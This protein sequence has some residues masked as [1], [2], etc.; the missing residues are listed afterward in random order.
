MTWAWPRPTHNTSARAAAPKSRFMTQ[1]YDTGAARLEKKST[2]PHDRGSDRQAKPP[3]HQ[4]NRQDRG[5]D[6]RLSFEGKG[7]CCGRPPGSW[8]NAFACIGGAG[9]FAR[10]PHYSAASH[11]R[12]SDHPPSPYS[13]MITVGSGPSTASAAVN[14]GPASISVTLQT[15]GGVAPAP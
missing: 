6:F 10:Q 9:G 5:G 1:F 12:G 13:C 2:L 4:M 7:F 3:A 8:R 15:P 14:C 11:G